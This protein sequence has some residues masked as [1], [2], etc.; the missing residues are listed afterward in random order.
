MNGQVE[1][2]LGCFRVTIFALDGLASM[3]CVCEGA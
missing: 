3:D 2:D 1:N